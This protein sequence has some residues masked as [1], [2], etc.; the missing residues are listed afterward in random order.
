MAENIR[1]N[2]TPIQRNH[3]DVATE[4]TQLHFKTFPVENESEVK[5]IFTE[6]YS[7]VMCLEATRMKDWTKLKDFLPEDI[8]KKLY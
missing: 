3:L 8:T 4:L 5:K 1:V 6:Y 2:P 7:L